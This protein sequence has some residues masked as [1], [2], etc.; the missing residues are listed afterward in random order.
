MP[1]HPDIDANLILQ[2]S[3]FIRSLARGLLRDQSLVDDVVQETLIK[4]LEKGPRSKG[5]LPGWL[6]IVTRNIAYKTYRATARR[7]AREEDAARPEAQSAAVDIVARGEALENLTSAVMDLPE[8]S[9]EVI[10]MRY[11]EGL[12]HAQI[13]AQLDLA[14]G[15][16][17]MRLHRAQ[18]LLQGRLD[19]Q[20]DGDRA[21][22]ISGLAGL[23]GVGLKDIGGG[24]TPTGGVAPASSTVI[25]LTAAAMLCLGLGAMLWLGL[26]PTDAVPSA[27]LVERPELASVQSG[28]DFQPLELSAALDGAR[29]GA[30]PE[31]LPA[32]LYTKPVPGAEPA[33][34][35]AAPFP[36]GSLQGTVVDELGE[37]VADAEVYAAWGKHPM[38]LRVETNEDGRFGIDVPKKIID[39]ALDGTY[40]ILLAATSEESAPTRIKAWPSEGPEDP[41]ASD[42]VQLRTRGPGGVLKGLVL[43]PDGRPIPGAEISLGQ[44]SRL[45][46]GFLGQQTATSENPLA[47]KLAIQVERVDTPLFQGHR[48]MRGTLGPQVLE[49]DGKRSRLLPAMTRKSKADGTF[50]F[51]GMELGQQQVRISARGYVPFTGT[52]DLRAGKATSRT[53]RLESGATLRGTLTRED[54]LPPTKGLL[55]AFHQDPYRVQTVGMRPDGSF[56]FHGLRPGQ[57]RIVAEE[58]RPRESQ[59]QAQRIASM[60]VTLNPGESRAITLAMREHELAQIRVLVRSEGE[61]APVVGLS[62]EVRAAANRVDR[63]AIYP[64]DEEGRASVRLETVRAAE[65]VISHHHFLAQGAQG[66]VLPGK[67]LSHYTPIKRMQPPTREEASKEILITLEENELLMGAVLMRPSVAGVSRFNFRDGFALLQPDEPFTYAGRSSG[68]PGQLRFNS[69]PA[70]D[71][72]L[73]Y[74]H[75]GLG[76]ISPYTV[77]VNSSTEEKPQDLGSLEL[78]KLGSL[79]L[80]LPSGRS[81]GGAQERTDSRWTDLDV[82]LLLPT[83]VGEAKI[84]MFH[85]R[86]ELPSSLDLAPGQY[87]LSDPSRP[88]LP[89][90]YVNVRPGEHVEIAWH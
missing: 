55:H 9:R 80:L 2:H 57:V 54:G 71:Y 59:A 49:S 3:G 73:I 42:Y 7:R 37:P 60:Q 12:S 53:F 1:A 83:Q 77:H 4:A 31:P 35:A 40:S 5:A 78:P 22:W 86:A 81:A 17:R 21:V 36:E 39:E 68:E 30:Q 87:V 16:V 65:W 74:P 52:V 43:G 48:N 26:Q 66:K 70:G 20:T 34:D 61:L 51:R 10:F 23:A 50:Q 64:L 85:G 38:T 32:R 18:K 13:G 47:P 41:S 82:K 11:Y 29:R 25:A 67:G 33:A 27:R 45:G 72:H 6:R 63:M 14:T 62:L 46:V 56:V 28:E 58:R 8:S 15:A 75:H 69:V 88:D 79:Q 90:Q 44:R 89:A 19:H 24:L 84:G 76:W